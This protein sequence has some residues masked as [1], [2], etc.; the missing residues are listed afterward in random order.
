MQLPAM[1]STHPHYSLFRHLG[2]QETLGTETLLF[3]ACFP[4]WEKGC[5]TQLHIFN[6]NWLAYLGA[7]DIYI[8]QTS[9]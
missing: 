6:S 1:L 7:E 5:D 4:L 2:L 9:S 3:S 8:A